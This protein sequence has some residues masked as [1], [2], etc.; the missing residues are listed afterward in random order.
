[1]VEYSISKDEN[2]Q[3]RTRALRFPLGLENGRDSVRLIRWSNEL[4][5]FCY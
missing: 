2:I 1:M 5:Y 4:V 3:P